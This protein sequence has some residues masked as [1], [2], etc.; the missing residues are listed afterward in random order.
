MTRPCPHTSRTKARRARLAA[1]LMA[2]SLLV[3]SLLVASASPQRPLPPIKPQVQDAPRTGS[4]IFL[5]KADKLLKAQADSFMVVTGNVHFSRGAMQMYCDSAHYFPDT[6]SMDAFGHVRM[7]QGDTLF[8]YADELNY[9]GDREVAYLYGTPTAPVRMINRDVTLTTDEFVYDLRSE[10]GYYYTGGTLT[11]ARNRLV[12]LQG[13]YIPATKEANF[14]TDVHLTSVTSDDTLHILTDTLYYNTATHLAL[15]NS[16]AVV[17]NSQATI[18][19]SEG[20]YNTATSEARLFSRSRVVTSRGSTLEGDTLFYD[21]NTG[22][23]EA[24]GAMVLT[25]SVRQTRL[26]GDYGFYNEFTDSAFVTG[27]ALAMEYSRPDTLYMHGRQIE[28]FLRID[29]LRTPADTVAGTPEL[30]TLDSTHITVAYPRVRFFRNDM[31]GVCDSM[32]FV[33][34][35]STLHMLRH[36]IVW[37]GDRQI[38]GN[39]IQVHLNDSTIDRATLPDMA[40]TAEHIEDEFYNQLSGKRMVAFFENSELRRLEVDGNVEAIMLPMEA[41]STYNKIVNM[42]S[43]HL[44]AT[45]VR[46]NLERMKTWPATSGTVTPL[47]LARRSLF[48]LPRFVWY[49][50]LRPSSPE[51]IFIIPPE[52]DAL[53][54]E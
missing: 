32:R 43:S 8:V 24:F 47:Y 16:P 54:A 51:D 26:C 17:R 40:F 13:E 11:D 38:F 48:T 53:M 36:P 2:A 31:Q 49:G 23:G 3:P 35:D 21:R 41:D 12:S 4:R 1:A 15:L 34:A 5:E 22:I 9:R 50:A 46:Q 25:D 30:V 52:M 6:E 29:T 44:T 42:E 19:T 7:E 20:D 39:V 37:S 33:E 18:Y 45:F 28:M 14:Y 27:R 10:F